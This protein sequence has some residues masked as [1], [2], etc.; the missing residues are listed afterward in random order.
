MALNPSGGGGQRDGGAHLGPTLYNTMNRATR[1]SP[2]AQELEAWREQ[3]SMNDY[4]E[5]ARKE[6]GLTMANLCAGGGLCLMGGARA[7]FCPI[8]TAEVVAA[9]QQLL[10]DISHTRCYGDVFGSEID[11]APRPNFMWVTVPCIDFSLSGSRQGGHGDTGWMFAESANT[12]LDISP[13]AFAIEQSG[14]IPRVNGGEELLQLCDTL[15]ADYELTLKVHKLWKWGD[16]TNRERLIIVGTHKRVKGGKFEWPEY[17]FDE[18]NAPTYRDIMVPDD[19]VPAHYWR[20]DTVPSVDWQE[21]KP[22]KLHKI[23]QIGDSWKMGYST[24][25]YSVYSL[26]SLPNGQTRYNGG[27][28]RPSEAWKQGDTISHTRMTATRETCRMANVP[29]ETDS[30]EKFCVS[31]M[32]GRMTP[33]DWLRDNVNQGV[34]LRTGYAVSKAV[35][36]YLEKAGVKPSG[37]KVKSIA[38]AGPETVSAKLHFNLKQCFDPTAPFDP[39]T[40]S[41]TKKR[42]GASMLVDSGCF[43]ES[44]V[45]DSMRSLLHDPHKS[46]AVI[47]IADATR[48][49]ASFAGDFYAEAENQ[50]GVTDFKPGAVFKFPVTSCSAT[51]DGLFAIEPYW[52]DGWDIHFTQRESFMEKTIDEVRE[53]IPFRRGERGGHQA[54]TQARARGPRDRRAAHPHR[55]ELLPRPHAGD[56]HRDGAAQVPQGLLPAR[57]RIRLRHVQRRRRAAQHGQGCTRRPAGQGQVKAGSHHARAAAGQLTPTLTLPLTLTP[58]LSRTLTLTIHP[59]TA[60]RGRHHAGDEGV[61]RCGARAVRRDGR[62][63]HLRRG[64]DGHGPHGQDVGLRAARGRARRLH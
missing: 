4:K 50:G 1:S 13:D 9:K 6:S 52:C 17:E 16:P 33:D 5:A 14:N 47:E 53:V 55:K 51:K 27:G 29:S 63:A 60:G 19:E 64:P 45:P 41:S 38:E 46:S 25:P 11:D 21:P 15:R 20:H 58:T 7:G 56:D 61:L 43:P 22:G 12:I 34:P 35:L 59:L 49:S 30:Y 42:V 40:E 57:A 8:W 62:A 36:D 10:E 24:N 3:W 2:V 31:H 48:L 28:R 18:L 23:G 32:P 39:F 54:R 44:I 37:Q 26:D